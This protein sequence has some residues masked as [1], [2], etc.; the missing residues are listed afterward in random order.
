MYITSYI[1]IFSYNVWY[2]CLSKDYLFS[3]HPQNTC[4]SQ[5]GETKVIGGVLSCTCLPV[6]EVIDPTH[7][8]EL[9][10]LFLSDSLAEISLLADLFSR[11]MRK[12]TEVLPGT[13]EF[14]GSLPAA[15]FS[16]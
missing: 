10:C 8:H 6:E 12:G 9:P 3:L 7:S 16:C 15:L 5:N 1:N 14:G 13:C 2:V 4:Y 11:S